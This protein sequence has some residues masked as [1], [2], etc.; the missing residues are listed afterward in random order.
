[1]TQVKTREGVSFTRRQMY[2]GFKGVDK[3]FYGNYLNGT[4]F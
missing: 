1:M 2:A 4:S 3:N